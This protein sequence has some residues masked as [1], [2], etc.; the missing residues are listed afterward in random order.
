[1]CDGVQG[2]EEKEELYGHAG[3]LGAAAA[4]WEDLRSKHLLA[5]LLDLPADEDCKPEQQ[6][7]SGAQH[8]SKMSWEERDRHMQWAGG[9]V[10]EDEGSAHG[11]ARQAA[12][13]A[14]GHHHPVHS[15]H[16]PLSENC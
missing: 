13:A 1:M 11:Q 15:K 6:E 10:N 5:A 16:R 2:E 9:G 12:H 3:M 14:K 7:D 4:V 8:D